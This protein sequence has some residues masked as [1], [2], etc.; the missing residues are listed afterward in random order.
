MNLS[1][2]WQTTRNVNINAN[3]TWSHCIGDANIG[4]SI[5]NPAQNYVHVYNRALDR[6]NCVSDRRHLF[7]L[8]VVA[9]TPRFSNKALRMAATDWVASVIYRYSSGAPLAVLSGLDNALT[10]FTLE[11]PNQVSPVTAAV[12]QGSAC[13]NVAPCISWFNPAAFQQPALGTLGNMGAYTAYGPS[14]F[15]F[16]MALVREFR[17]AEGKRLELRGEAFN[18]TNSLRANN[19]G[20]TLS[21][22]NTFGVILSA[23]D[24]R[25]MQLAVK[26]VF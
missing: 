18:V 2:Q 3:Y 17:V 25:I 4:G 24:P 19:P 22:P 23:M 26:F 15:Q 1:T 10:G 9:R 14:F 21:T 8:T 13:P 5:P 7:N 16:D 12:N 11:R 20:V 6:G